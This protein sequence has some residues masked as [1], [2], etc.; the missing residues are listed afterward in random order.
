M[1]KKLTKEEKRAQRKERV[2]HRKM[3]FSKFA[4]K[5]KKPKV[6]KPKSYKARKTGVALAW[7]AIAAPTIFVAANFGGTSSDATEAKRPVVQMKENPATSQAA[8]Q[9]A[10]DFTEK[11]FFWKTG[12]DGRGLREKDLS[13]YLAEGLDPFAGLDMDNLKSNSMLKDAKIRN[14]EEQ[15][16]NKAKITLLATY[17]VTTEGKPAGDDKKP[18][19]QKKTATKAIVVPIKY[20]GTTYGV[21]ELPTFTGTSQKTNLKV[22]LNNTLEKSSNTFIV[23]KI[24]NFLETFFKSYSE[25]SKDQ[26]SY[27]LDDKK[28]QEGLQK[29]LKFTEVENVEV[30]KGTKKGEYIVDCLVH[31]QD[32]DSQSNITTKY[33]LTV[34][35]QD[36]RY[37]VTKIN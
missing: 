34:E 7:V 22:D 6:E 15:G 4:N 36:T 3:V 9:F 10:K 27:I 16:K 2:N 28:H 18:E 14:I 5:N 24:Q 33:R 37:I 32:P 29:S 31:F 1:K 21:Y 25:D 11:Y 23:Q 8:V 35:K 30:Y 20:T 19:Q 13:V 26:L 12:D 17:E